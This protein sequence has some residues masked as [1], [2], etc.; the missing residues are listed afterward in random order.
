MKRLV[1]FGPGHPFRGGIA[2][3]TTALVQALEDRGHD[4]L[5]LTP[6]RQ[7]PGWLFPGADDRD[8]SAC[9][10]TGNA[11][12]LYAP[13]EPWTWRS[14]LG[15]ARGHEADAWIVPFWTWAWAPLWHAVLGSRSRPPVVA[16]VHNPVDHEASPPRRWAARSVLRRCDAL[17]THGLALA[18]MLQRSYRG[19]PVASHLLPPSGGVTDCI[20]AVDRVAVRT[21][22]GVGSDQRLALFAG[23]IRP[24]KGVDLALRGV[25]A[26]PEETRW[27]LHVAGEA[28][29]GLGESL[30][31]LHTALAHPDRVSFETAWVSDRRL[32][33]LLVAADVV[34]LP[35]RS[36]SQSAMAPLALATGT[37]VLT[38]DVGALAEA[39]ADGRDGRVVQPGSWAAIAEAL[40]AMDDDALAALAEGARTTAMRR[41]WS[42]YAGVLLDLVP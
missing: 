7:Y 19:I 13:L 3:T 14:A 39:V 42:A 18:A 27:R 16:V 9:P 15:A 31:A 17:M 38:T 2:T 22:L 40:A 28:W 1:V 21:S 8:P 23:L 32:A 25:D 29:G 24:Y 10:I 4:V 35:Y 11:R 12:S 36:G 5:F 33:E 34:V 41:T 26:L 20:A 6:R 30:R 37:P